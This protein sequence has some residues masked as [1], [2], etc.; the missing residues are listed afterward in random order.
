MQ[1]RAHGVAFFRS[2]KANRGNGLVPAEQQSF[3]SLGHDGSPLTLAEIN[4]TQP[5]VLG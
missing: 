1:L 5:S 2:I 4:L 3:K